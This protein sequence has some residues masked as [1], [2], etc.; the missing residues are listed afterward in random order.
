[1]A[2]D[3]HIEQA[4]PM[5]IQRYLRS[6]DYPCSKDELVEKAKEAGADE[7]VIETLEEMPDEIFES[8]T[9]VAQSIGKIV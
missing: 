6:V 5:T 2:N 9:D 8:P 1:M 7:E 4:D 3:N